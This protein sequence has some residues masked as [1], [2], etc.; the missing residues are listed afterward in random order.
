VNWGEVRANGNSKS[1]RRVQTGKLSFMDNAIYLSF[2][3]KS[4]SKL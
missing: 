4:S 1:G 3:N 2:P